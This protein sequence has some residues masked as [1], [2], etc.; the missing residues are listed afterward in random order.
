MIIFYSIPI[1]ALRLL[2]PLR[3]TSTLYDYG[4]LEQDDRHD[5]PGGFINAIAMSRMPGKP[6]TDYPDLS[7]VEGEGLKRK[8]LQILE[9]IRLLGWEL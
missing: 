3:E 8:V 2:E 6:A 1:R 9:G 7:D 4:V 5:Y